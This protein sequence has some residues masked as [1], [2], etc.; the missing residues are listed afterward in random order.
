[1]TWDSAKRT[2]R[3]RAPCSRERAGLVGPLD[4]A[5]RTRGSASAYQRTI[6]SVSESSRSSTMISS[7]VPGSASSLG[8]A[9][10]SRAARPPA[11]G[12]TTATVGSLSGGATVVS[13]YDLACERFLEPC[14]QGR[15]SLANI[16][17]WSQT[18]G[19]AERSLSS[20][21]HSHPAPQHPG[22]SR[23]DPELPVPG[24]C[25]AAITRAPSGFAPPAKPV[26]SVKPHSRGHPRSRVLALDV[27]QL[28][29]Q[30][31]FRLM[32]VRA[33]EHPCYKSFGHDTPPAGGAQPYVEIPVSESGELGIEPV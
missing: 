33:V 8:K 32:H 9:R 7:E 17:P 31:G 1:M 12:I 14:G 10:R 24:R 20:E 13:P 29:R 22:I 28:L 6:A 5:H 26:L 23:F 15:W 16:S 19:D 2:P 25:A 27:G 21:P 4:R 18:A 11:V 30:P 3:S